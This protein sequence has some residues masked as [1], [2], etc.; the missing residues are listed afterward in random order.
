MLVVYPT[1][2][3][4]RQRENEWLNTHLTSGGGRGGTCTLL[5]ADINLVLLPAVTVFQSFFFYFNP[6]IFV[7]TVLVDWA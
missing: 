1:E 5:D 2:L 6:D 4:F 3:E 7:L